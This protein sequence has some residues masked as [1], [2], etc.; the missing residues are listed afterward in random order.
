MAAAATD[1][2]RKLARKWVGQIGASGV[3][4]DTGT[5]IP[6][7]STTNLPTDT[8]VTLVIDRVDSS[9]TKTPALEETIV[10]VVSGN[11]IVNALRGVEGTAQAHSAGAVVEVLVT[12]DGYNDIIDH[13]LV[14]HLQDG[15]HAG[16]AITASNIA[17]SAIVAGNI[18]ASGITAGNLA[19]SA[20]L[21]GNLAASAI[22]AG[23]IGASAVTSGNLAAS[24]VLTGNIGA[25]AVLVNNLSASSVV[26]GNLNFSPAIEGA[27][28][29]Y[30]AT[31]TIVGWVSFTTKVIMY[32]KIGKLVFVQYNL[33]GTSNSTS[34]SF[35]VPTNNDSYVLYSNSGVAGDN[36]GARVAGMVYMA[37]GTNVVGL[38]D[39][40][41]GTSW[42]ASG[43]K[44]AQGQFCY[45]EA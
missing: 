10:G 23:N 42:T 6:L 44:T 15:R 5:T 27:W 3:S 28:T 43:A 21:A 9:G 30:S 19:A 8:A 14:G 40:V 32:K 29:D 24:A 25:S 12:A 37:S 38:Y 35:T 34:T 7:A 22:L 39:T 17:A 4:D 16:S 11:N 45:V 18:A 1:K 20:V 13:L 41:D 2:L 36:G 33:I 26:L 31:S